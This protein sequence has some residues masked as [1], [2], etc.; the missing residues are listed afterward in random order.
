VSPFRSTYPCGPRDDSVFWC[1]R[2]AKQWNQLLPCVVAV[3]LAGCGDRAGGRQA[4]SGT[5]TLKG[6]P[7]TKNTSKPRASNNSNKPHRRERVSPPKD[8]PG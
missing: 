7:S 6:E 5:I 4:V 8:R 1:C 2:L 3:L